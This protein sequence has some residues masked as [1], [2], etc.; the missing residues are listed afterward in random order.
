MAF[1]YVVFNKKTNKQLRTFHY[2]PTIKGDYLRAENLAIDF[3]KREHVN[4]YPA[5]VEQC[6]LLDFGAI[7]FD[8]DD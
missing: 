6:H 5:T 7:V 4:G 1:C 2:L 3:A 8:S